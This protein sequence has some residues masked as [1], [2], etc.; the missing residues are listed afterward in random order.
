MKTVSLLLS[1][2]FA[3]FFVPAAYALDESADIASD[4]VVVE[5]KP[6]VIKRILNYFDESNK[7]PITRK[8]DFSLIGG[9]YYSSDSKFGIG[10]VAAGIYSTAPEDTLTK[11]S[12]M[13]LC[14]KA[15]TA[16]HFELALE[17]QHI[18][19]HDRY[20][21]DYQVSFS[22][23]NT[24]YW[25]IGYPQ[26]SNDNNESKYKYLASH[27]EAI[28]SINL[29]RN[30]YLGPLMTFD[31][32]NARSFQKPEL[33]AGLPHRTFNY[34]IGAS[35]RFDTRDNLTD[36]QKGILL[37]FDQTF[38]FG[39]M[40]NRYPFKSNELTAAWFGPLWKGCTFAT[41]LHWRITWGDTPWGLMPYLGGS[42]TM[43]GYFEGRYRDKSAAD[44]CVELRQHVWR[45]N[46]VVV[47]AGCGSV[48]SHLSDITFNRLLPN[49]GFGYRWEFK[50]NV[51]V[52]VD[53]GF[54][55]HGSGLFF[56]INEAF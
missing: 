5:A 22:S 33:W 28:F 41:R 27:A 51:N 15:T 42:R 23:I 44:I 21:F 4:T 20:R 2:V 25:G 13:S 38:D 29:G 12:E 11:P 48:F 9:P 18:F 7:K 46:G 26:C 40:G 3:L 17:G 30:V 24:K 39:W 32:V 31:Y 55:K 53:L 36:T 50:K 10:V 35:L 1:A 6:G 49:F 45:R 37:R 52:R 8:M 19:P 43:R 14:F 34:G 56:G 47:W 16:S 54:G